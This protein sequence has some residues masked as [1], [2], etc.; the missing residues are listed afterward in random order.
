MEYV[1]CSLIS[2]RYPCID[3]FGTAWLA[4]TS[5]WSF[6]TRLSLMM[7]EKLQLESPYS[8]PS[9]LGTEVYPLSWRPAA[10]EKPPDISGLPSLDD[11]LHL[12]NIF[13]YHL[14]Q[15]YRFFDE[16]VFTRKLHEF[17]SDHSVNK[18]MENYLWFVQFLLVL[19]FGNALL[20]RTRRSKE[21]PGSKWLLRAMSLLPSHTTLWD[22]SVLAIEVLALVGL[23]LYSV[24][25]RESAHEYVRTIEVILCLRKNM[26][27]VTFWSDRSS[28]THLTT[29]W[30][31]HRTS[32]GRTR[33]GDSQPLPQYL[34]DSLRVGPACFILSWFAYDNTG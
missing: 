14:H 21:P 9:S 25:H 12:L 2:V 8:V 17:Y 22:D 30:I 3:V 4:P 24:D 31:T 33:R 5:T 18:P 6:T 1:F 15:N 7:A 23:F 34:V 11:A 10:I 27:M 19:A 29:Q 20:L 32:G 16:Y 26:L 28:Y 13:K